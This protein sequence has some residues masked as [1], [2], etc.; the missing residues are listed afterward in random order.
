MRT[1]SLL[2]LTLA[3]L[4][5]AQDDP[6]R[7][8]L[9]HNATTLI[10]T[11]SSGAGLVQ[12]GP[13]R[14]FCSPANKTF[15]PPPVAGISYS[16]DGDGNFEQVEYR[17]GSNPAKPACPNATLLF[18]HGKYQLLPN[19]SIILDPIPEDG[20]VQTQSPCT[21][22]SSTIQQF[23]VTVLFKEWR[24]FFDPLSQGYHLHL[25]R[26][27][28]APLNKMILRYETPIMH[29]TTTI[30]KPE[31]TA[32][33]RRRRAYVEQRSDAPRSATAAGGIGLMMVL[34]GVVMLV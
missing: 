8:D 16:F 23:N 18:Q 6:I 21:A 5:L 33:A 24:I 31:P 10:G 17:F 30:L 19:G 26:F 13:V 11:W 7:Y 3:A 32:P 22:H 2:P 1:L 27:D 15:N 12:T 20:L 29:P 25:F 9:E 14:N 28:G 34:L 4:V